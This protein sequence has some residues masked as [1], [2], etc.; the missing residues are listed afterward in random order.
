MSGISEVQGVGNI[1]G[2][3]AQGSKATQKASVFNVHLNH[4]TSRASS[5]GKAHLPA[6][7]SNLA[8]SLANCRKKVVSKDIF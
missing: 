5:S 6:G 1:P 3:R 4:T 2:Y 7:V 8:T